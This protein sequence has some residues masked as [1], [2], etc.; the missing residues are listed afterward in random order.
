MVPHNTFA[1]GRI[2]R[3]RF[4]TAVGASTTVF[5]VGISGAVSSDG[6]TETELTIES[7]DGTELGATLYEPN[8][9]GQHPAVL[10][11]H[12]YGGN[13]SL[14]QFLSDRGTTY[15][16]N[17][18]V[19]LTYDS[20]GFGDSGG[21]VGLNGPNE[22]RDAQHLITHLAALDSVQTDGPDN[23]RVG[24]DGTSY[25]GGIQLNTAIAEANGTGLP[26]SN[27]RI[28]AIVPRWAWHDLTY[29]LAPNGVIKRGWAL[30]LTVAGAAGAHLTG[31]DAF[32][33]LQGQAPELYELLYHGLVENEL[34]DWGIR[35]LTDR[36]PVGK[37]DS[38]TSPAL[39]IHGFSDTLFTPLEALWNARA[40]TA[41]RLVLTN[42]GHSLSGIAAGLSDEGSAIDA[43]AHTWLDTHLRGDETTDLPAVTYYD[44]ESGGYKTADGIPASGTTWEEWS[45][46]GVTDDETS[47][48]PNTG[49]IESPIS[50]LSFEWAI[51]RELTL[52][53]PPELS[54]T[55]DPFGPECR[56]FASLAHVRDGATTQ[57][58]DQVTPLRIEGDGPLERTVSLPPLSRSFTPGDALRLTVST[59]NVGYQPSRSAVGVW[60]HHGTAE[61]TRLRLPI[62]D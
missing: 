51:D 2:D 60:L 33:F 56:L 27:D 37:I 53:G 43:L 28:D 41:H 3:R 59:A 45:V 57:I 23:P 61:E 16:N 30:L 8:A 14:S 42:G 26:E 20:R 19:V 11:T 62:R 36:S 47:Y 34:P 24:M 54:L 49:P 21:E 58:D 31:T 1:D 32:D 17:G 10:M 39:F 48:A 35:Y 4:L 38:I 9:G 5:G 7:F 15:A 22:V 55:V 46:A 29:S 40:S 52:F 13:R 50:T 25:G 6:I 12:G 44:S 18:Y